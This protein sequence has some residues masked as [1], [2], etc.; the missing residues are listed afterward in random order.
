MENA[1]NYANNNALFEGTFLTSQYYNPAFWFAKMES[2][3]YSITS[4]LS[5]RE[6]IHTYYFLLFVFGTF[7]TMLIMY[8]AVRL[9]ELRRKE[10]AHL[11]HELEE[12]KHHQREREKKQAASTSSGVNPRWTQTLTYLFSKNPNDWKLA[13][14]EADS[15]LDALLDQ[16]GFQGENLGEKLKNAPPDKFR[17]LAIAWEAHTVRNRIAHEGAAFLLTEKE[18]RRII[19]LY[20]RIFRDYG[21]I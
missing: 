4:L 17:D 15:M 13:V 9:V 14:M 5:S 1:P 18:S 12:Y 3:F 20:E 19:A 6:V 2:F 21:Y 16:L 7:F 10:H 11:H 8:C